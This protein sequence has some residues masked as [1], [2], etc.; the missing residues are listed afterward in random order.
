MNAQHLASNLN[1][2]FTEENRRVIFW[3][4]D[5]GEFAEII[6]DIAANLEDAELVR[7]DG[8]FETAVSARR[9]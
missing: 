1:R 8:T 6:Y 4:D 3:D 5:A 9:V 2:I 7:R